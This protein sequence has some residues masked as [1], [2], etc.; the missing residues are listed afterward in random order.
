LT[1]RGIAKWLLALLTL[2]VLAA[3]VDLSRLVFA[4]EGSRTELVNDVRTILDILF[5]PL[6]GL[7]GAVTGFYFG[8]HA[9]EEAR[10]DFGSDQDD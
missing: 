7:I 9:R 4:A 6:V 2:V 5:P 8:T 1:E 10:S 3:L